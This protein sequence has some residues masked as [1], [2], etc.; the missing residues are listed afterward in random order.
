MIKLTEEKSNLNFSSS[1]L[2]YSQIK[3]VK[4]GRKEGRK[5]CMEVIASI[6]VI[7]SLTLR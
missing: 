6:W 2:N 5:R 1:I 7:E 4:K 3:K